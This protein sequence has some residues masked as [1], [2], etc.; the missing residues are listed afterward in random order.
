[1]VL[2]IRNDT[3]R[4]ALRPADFSIVESMC[5]VLVEELENAAPDSTLAGEASAWRYWAAFCE[6]LGTPPLRSDAAANSGVDPAGHSRETLLQAAAVP[7]IF[8]RMPGRRGFDEHGRRLPP[9]PSSVANV[10]R[11]VRRAHKRMGVPMASM[12]MAMRVCE[13]LLNRYRDEHGPEALQPHRKEPLTNPLVRAL[14][15]LRHG[16]LV[17]RDRVDLGNIEWISLR[18]MYCTLAQTGFRK[19]EVTVPDGKAFGRRHLS[20]A[21]VAYKL[22]GRFVRSP[23]PEQLRAMREGDFVLLTVAPS[24]ADQHGIHWGQAPVYLPFHE[25][26]VVNAARAL[27]DL[28]LAWPLSGL[29]R[30]D[31]PLFCNALRLPVHHS[32]AD[33]RFREALAACGVPP[34]ELGKYSMHSWRIY[35]ACAL[36][37]KG[38]SH[39]Q[40]MSML[41]WRSDEALKIYARM[42]DAE[43]GTWLDVASAA[44]I[45]SIRTANLPALYSPEQATATALLLEGAVTADVHA[46]SVARRPVVDADGLMGDIASGMRGLMAAAATAD[47]AADE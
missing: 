11:A 42:N 21:N 24:K 10:I 2:A 28:E 5:Q 4:Y 12:S 7:W 27:R 1:M 44:D 16:S 29:E 37:A 36:L 47:E 8:E 32:Q 3:S 9:L 46:V 31:H 45:S 35:L 6:E 34:A 25:H 33:K 13:S 30:R 19:S 22:G 38:A 39:S 15:S 43:Y 14:C 23:S 41:R 18:A 26:S 40:I 17:G 20:R